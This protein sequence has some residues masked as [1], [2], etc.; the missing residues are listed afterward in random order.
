MS[1]QGQVV[2]EGGGLLSVRLVVAALAAIALVLFIFQNTHD[3]Q[4]S[5]LWM[6]GT[7]PLYLLVLVTV[8]LTLVLA[9][10]GAWFLRRRD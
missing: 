10:I 7:A 2:E 1:E 3:A 8:G 9:T 6:D 5:F 4:V